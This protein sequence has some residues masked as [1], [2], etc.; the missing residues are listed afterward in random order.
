MPVEHLRKPLQWF[1]WPMLTEIARKLFHSVEGLYYQHNLR[2]DL[3]TG[4]LKMA[5]FFYKNGNGHFPH[6]SRKNG[7]KKNDYI[8]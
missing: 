2:N 8:Q 3:F 4:T 6:F 7:Y 1:D 5:G